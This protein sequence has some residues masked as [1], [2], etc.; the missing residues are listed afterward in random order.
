MLTLFAREG[1]GTGEVEVRG[2]QVVV[3]VQRRVRMG[4]KDELGPSYIPFPSP[5]HMTIYLYLFGSSHLYI[6]PF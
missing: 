5:G 4:V 1:R 3:R 6:C 2:K